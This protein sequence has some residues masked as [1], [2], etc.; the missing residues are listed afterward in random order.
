[1][2]GG[3]HT[4]MGRQAKI[5]RGKGGERKGRGERGRKRKGKK[6]MKTGVWIGCAVAPG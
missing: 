6:R 2:A 1:M 3:R 4:K 5:G